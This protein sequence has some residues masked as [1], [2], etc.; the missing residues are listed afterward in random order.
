MVKALIRGNKTLAAVSATLAIPAGI[1]TGAVAD[2]DPTGNTDS[3]P[4]TGA[5]TTALPANFL[6]TE[7]RQ[8]PGL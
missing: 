7:A 4:R 3:D 2:G 5:A 8:I 1:L 6:T